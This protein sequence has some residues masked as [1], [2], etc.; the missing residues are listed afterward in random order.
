MSPSE[1]RWH[2]FIEVFDVEWASVF[3]SVNFS[4]FTSMEGICL[5]GCHFPVSFLIMVQV[6]LILLLDLPINLL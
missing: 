5:V 4:L 6:V 1:T 2:L 3:G